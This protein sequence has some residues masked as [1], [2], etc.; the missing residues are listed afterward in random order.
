LNELVTNAAKHGSGKI[1]VEYKI[2]GSRHELIVCD[3]GRG[4][5]ENFD[6]DQGAGLGMKVVTALAKQLGGQM[7]A[8]PNPAGKGAC[9]KVTFQS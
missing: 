4:L 9:F 8:Q 6:P 7:S 3:E 2:D 1:E 5:P